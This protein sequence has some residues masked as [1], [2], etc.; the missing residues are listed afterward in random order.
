MH[1]ENEIRILL[2]PQNRGCTTAITCTFVSWQQNCEI[3]VQRHRQV[4]VSPH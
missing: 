1:V 2:R 3:I 4:I